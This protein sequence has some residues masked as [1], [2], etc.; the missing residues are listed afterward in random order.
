VPDAPD[1]EQPLLIGMI[2]LPPLPGSPGYVATIG[3]AFFEHALADARTLADAGFAHAMVENFGDAPFTGGAI[4]PETVAAVA[5]VVRAVR[6]SSGLIVGVNCLRNDARSA[7]GIAAA[8]GAAFIRVNVHSG[9]AATDQ[10]MLT[11]RADE[12]LRVRARICPQVRIF[13]DVHVKHAVPINQPDIALAAEETAYRGG[14]DALIVSGAT[15]GRPVDTNA[16]AR[17]RKAVPDRLLLVGSGVTPDT[18]RATLTTCDGA[19]VGTS[20]KPGGDIAAP[21]D[22][23]LARQMIAAK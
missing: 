13:A 10:G 15:T 8:T 11:G 3:E 20:L 9:M 5:L 18:L 6:Q 2:H 4:A 14:A 22:A 17:V 1:F 7:L 19:I 12:T 16:L 23:D 21:I